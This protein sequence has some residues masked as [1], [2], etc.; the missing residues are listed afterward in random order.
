VG[1]IRI[2]PTHVIKVILARVSHDT[3]SLEGVVDRR[4]TS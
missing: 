4:D 3:R 2:G 1:S